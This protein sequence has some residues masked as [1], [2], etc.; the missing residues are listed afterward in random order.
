MNI[1][2]NGLWIQKRNIQK[3]FYVWNSFWFRTLRKKK[4]PSNNNH[5]NQNENWKSFAWLTIRHSYSFFAIQNTN[6]ATTC[7]HCCTNCS[8]FSIRIIL[9]YTVKRSSFQSTSNVNNC[10]CR[11]VCRLFWIS[12]DAFDT[13]RGIRS[14]NPDSDDGYI[15]SP[16]VKIQD[17]ILTTQKYESRPA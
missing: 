16:W 14:S 13:F 10:G 12:H 17:T 7:S 9:I 15:N 1:M 8:S 6:S 5:F 3:T 4:Q 11:G 2:N